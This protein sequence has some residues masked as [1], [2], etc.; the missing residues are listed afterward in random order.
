MKLFVIG[1][2]AFLQTMVCAAESSLIGGKPVPAGTYPEI[3]Y[4]R[5]GNS[6]CSATIVGPSVILTAGHCV[7]DDGSIGP[8]SSTV[9]FVVEQTVYTAKCRQAP[10]YRDKVEDHDMALCKTDKP[11]SVK[12][13]SIAKKGPKIGDRVV[14]TGYGC[15]KK[16]GG[17]GND[18]VLRSGKSKVT[19][20]PEGENH[21]F[22]TQK[23]AALCFGDSG[24]P[25]LVDNGKHQLIGVNS[26]GNIRDLSLLT[27]LYIE[28]SQ[29]FF[30]EFAEEF[31]VDV[32]GVTKVC[33]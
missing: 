10:L 18:G 19:K 13:A 8:V 33:Q 24:G 17:G 9:D 6:R 14:L 15:V 11:L 22:Y 4:I 23:D 3:V 20:L 32:C 30:R 29:D 26:R 12:P 25:S 5:S 16:G 1:L 31:S 7:A 27:A 2:L 21:W 28:A